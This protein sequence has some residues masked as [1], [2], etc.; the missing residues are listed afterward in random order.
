MVWHAD[1][2][3]Q[4]LRQELAAILRLSQNSTASKPVPPANF[5]GHGEACVV[6]PEATFGSAGQLVP[7]EV[8]DSKVEVARLALPPQHRGQSQGPGACQCQCHESRQGVPACSNSTE[9]RICSL[10]DQA[11]EAAKEREARLVA[12]FTRVI[13]HLQVSSVLA[14]KNPAGPAPARKLYVHSCP[15]RLC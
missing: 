3:N 4:R 5:T 13:Q 7:L 12:K 9:F 1:L 11:Q 10:E 14:S 8:V 15:V 2:E 6:D